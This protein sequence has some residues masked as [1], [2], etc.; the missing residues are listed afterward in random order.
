[1]YLVPTFHLNKYN[2]THVT[3]LCIFAKKRRPYLCA[4]CLIPVSI[5][6]TCHES[7]VKRKLVHLQFA[8]LRVLM[9]TTVP[10]RCKIIQ[11]KVA[12]HV[13]ILRSLIFVAQKFQ[14][15]KL[16]AR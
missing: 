11:V 2:N 6:L 12:I 1:M 15:K 3:T 5:W 13:Y 7:R 9:M 14:K 8:G 4:D 10:T 16:R